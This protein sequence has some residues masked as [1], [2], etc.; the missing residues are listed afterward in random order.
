LRA[1]DPE[2]RAR[3]RAHYVEGLNF[4]K[5]GARWGVDRSVASRRVATAR[6]TLLDE[7]RRALATLA[8]R[9]SPTSRDSLM[10]T[11]GSQIQITLERALVT[12]RA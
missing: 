10:M 3:I 8:P 6:K 4:E 9:L 5:L 7:T 11:L 12:E 2:T 1:L